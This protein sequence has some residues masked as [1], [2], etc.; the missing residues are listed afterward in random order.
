MV[1][2]KDVKKEIQQKR[3]LYFVQELVPA[4]PAIELNMNMW[5]P[6]VRWL[7]RI[8]SVSIYCC[9]IWTA[10]F[11]DPRFSVVIDR[12]TILD[13]LGGWFATPVPIFSLECS[14]KRW[15]WTLAV[16]SCQCNLSD[17][18]HTA[19]LLELA[20]NAHYRMTNDWY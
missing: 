2:Y 16:R 5:K 17:H 18:I 15:C 9:A 13:D 12:H 1:K 4:S 20:H 6:T 7:R 10:S 14:S 3:F 19:N 8:F 11:R